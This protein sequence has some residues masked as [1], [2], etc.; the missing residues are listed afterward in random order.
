VIAGARPGRCR[1]S[2]TAF[3]H[4]TR[5]ERLPTTRLGWRLYRCAECGARVWV[6][7]SRGFVL[8]MQTIAEVNE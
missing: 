2:D 1:A 8:S 7:P 6:D 5:L 4:L 3:R